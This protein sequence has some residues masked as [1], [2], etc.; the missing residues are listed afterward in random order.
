MAITT[1]VPDV[2]AVGGL[3]EASDYNLFRLADATALAA[4]ITAEIAIADAYI[5]TVAPTAYASAAANTVT[6]LGRAGTYLVLQQLVETLKSR[7]VEGTHWALDQEESAR[8]EALVDTEY[9]KQA[10]RILNL[11]GANETNA[12]L[13]L[14]GLQISGEID[15]TQRL[16]A[17]Q[18]AQQI[19]DEAR[20]FG[21][22]G[23]AAI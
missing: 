4:R 20:G 21:A 2:L 17:E 22:I 5:A 15:L 1:S 3:G 12:P 14:P 11:F 8:F 18:R 23:V 9:E 19:I 10:N 13:V 16:T 7:K 6:L